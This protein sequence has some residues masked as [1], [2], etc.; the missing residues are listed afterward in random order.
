MVQT[1]ECMAE[2]QNIKIQPTHSV[3]RAETLL[4]RV[5]RERDALVESVREQRRRDSF[6]ALEMVVEELA[7]DLAHE[8]ITRDDIPHHPMAPL[9]REKLQLFHAHGG[10]NDQLQIRY[11]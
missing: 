6:D 10:T 1:L 11:A 4:A 3:V 9:L 8:F 2:A 5:T 7:N